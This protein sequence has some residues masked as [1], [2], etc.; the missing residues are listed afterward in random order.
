[1]P[2]NVFGLDSRERA[3]SRLR[4]SAT[5]CVKRSRSERPRLRRSPERID[6]AERQYLAPRSLAADS[7][8]S[9]SGEPWIDCHSART[10]FS[11]PQSTKLS[12]TASSVIVFWWPIQ[13]PS[14]AFIH[15][16]A[17][18]TP[19]MLGDDTSEHAYCVATNLSIAVIHRRE[20][21]VHHPAKLLL[22]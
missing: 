13:P 12:P 1:M 19:R 11:L 14:E 15:S 16:H 10:P 18:S 8:A 21:V 3:Y 20:T 4:T 22:R 9:C 5:R 2:D 17:T 6:K 7:L